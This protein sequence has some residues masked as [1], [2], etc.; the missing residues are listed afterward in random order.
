MKKYVS[1]YL[2][3]IDLDS[4][5]LLF[6][7]VNGCLD[8]VPRSVADAMRDSGGPGLSALGEEDLQALEKRGHITALPPE[9][10]LSRFRAFC[11]AVHAKK[12]Q[13][14][15]Y[16]GLMLLMS[17]N[18]NLAC[19]YCYQQEHRPHKS[20]AVMTPELVEEVFERHLSSLIPRAS[21]KGLDL[22]FYGGEPFLPCNEP[23]IKKAL[24]YARAN[25]MRVSAIS[26]ATRVHL[27]PEIFGEGPG[28]VNSVQVSLDGCRDL[29]DKSRIPS[30]GEP[31][32][33]V[34]VD[35]IAM[36]L[37]RGARVSIR[38]NL[39]RKTMAAV[40]K[41]I[42]ELKEKGVLGHKNASIYASPLHDN[43]AEVDATDFMDLSELSGQVF[44]L[45]IDLEHPVSLRANDMSYLFSLE[46]GLGLTRTCFCMQ[47][48]QRVLVLDPFGDLYACF[49][50]AGYPEHRIGRVSREGVEFFPLR[51]RYKTRS[52]ANMEE[53]MRC[54]VA[55]SCGGQC[56]AQ[57]RAK[58]GDIFK[59]H[60]SDIKKVIL[61]GLKLAYEKK[62]SDPAAAGAAVSA[63]PPVSVHG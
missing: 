39:D 51:E 21:L 2:N 27:M 25:E 56:G 47:T 18:C 37:A 34:I 35:N 45:G 55:L 5:A 10:E 17:Y 46:K 42:G 12:E 52:I 33:D 57:C 4:G 30:S 60:C 40:P 63:A 49:E 41:L 61:S 13:E 62:R 6:N 50:E 11:Q 20:G 54:S 58:T 23:V 7:G 1:R 53:C 43:I 32:F 38:L 9:E 19:K 26:N 44:E 29:H 15:A 31:T 24:G 8:E 22:T 3:I 36:I 59:P 48:M 16:G 28:F 14:A